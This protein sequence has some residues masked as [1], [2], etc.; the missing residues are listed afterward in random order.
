MISLIEQTTKSYWVNY[1]DDP[2]DWCPVE[3][4]VYCVV[5]GDEFLQEDEPIV[6][7][8]EYVSVHGVSYAVCNVQ[9]VSPVEGERWFLVYAH[10]GEKADPLTEAE[11]QELYGT[12][13][14]DTYIATEDTS[15]VE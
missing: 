3:P 2:C 14:S 8:G 6:G 7:L 1:S 11:W 4:H 13:I 10:P 9:E 5:R 15:N 12:P